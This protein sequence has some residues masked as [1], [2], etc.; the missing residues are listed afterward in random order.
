MP[1]DKT[2]L[3]NDLEAIFDNESAQTDNPDQSR[4]RMANGIA[5]AIEKYV[6]SGDG[7][8]QPGSLQETGGNIVVHVGSGAVIK[9]N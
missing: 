6:K 4:Q 9:M 7:F 3:I 1:L 5:N 8:Y 2:T